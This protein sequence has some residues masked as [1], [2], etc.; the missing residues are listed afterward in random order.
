[1]GG[2]VSEEKSLDDV[3]EEESMGEVLDE[4]SL[5]KVLEKDSVDED[6]E[7]ESVGEVLEETSV[8][9]EPRD[10]LHR[11]LQILQQQRTKSIIE[12]Q[13]KMY[14]PNCGVI[15]ERRKVIKEKK[16]HS[17]WLRLRLAGVR[18]YDIVDIY[19]SRR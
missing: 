13:Q 2:E 3:L 11:A 1:M 14:T 17:A 8:H 4:E 7:E 5:D 19:Y 6:L 18:W 10:R 9:E 16:C 15:K 12:R